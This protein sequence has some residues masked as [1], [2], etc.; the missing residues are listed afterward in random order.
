MKKWLAGNGQCNLSETVFHK[1]HSCLDLKKIISSWIPLCLCLSCCVVLWCVCTYT[2]MCEVP[3]LI[4]MRVVQS[5]KVRMWT[6]PALHGKNTKMVS[7]VFFSFSC[8]CLMQQIT[9]HQKHSFC[10]L[11]FPEKWSWCIL[12]KQKL[13]QCGNARL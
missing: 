9:S 12:W 3:H 11:V 8:K 10:Q 7:F 4:I 6:E 2:C 13:I 1:S 5:K